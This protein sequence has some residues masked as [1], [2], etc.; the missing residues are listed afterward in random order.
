M[1]I[2]EALDS[3]RI[4]VPY[5]QH[6]W[7]PAGCPPKPCGRGWRGVAGLV[8]ALI[9]GG[10]LNFRA[11]ETEASRPTQV[12]VAYDSLSG[13]TEKAAAAVVEGARQLT[14]VQVT[15]KRVEAVVREDLEAADGLVLGC[16]TYYGTMPGRMKT[17]IDDWSWKMKVDLTDKVGGAFA[18]GGGQTGGKEFT[19][20]S[21]LMFMVNNRMVV[22]GPLYR[23]EKTGSVWAEAG[24]TAMTGPADPGVG[25]VELDSARR[26]GH[27]VAELA[28]KLRR[29]VS[30]ASRTNPPSA[31]APE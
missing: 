7:R 31:R 9:F 19:V 1:R 6:G 4:G 13:H 15:L 26:L 16:P 8:V 23:N 22:A 18:T 27:R 10:T 20:I 30:S 14:G 2:S 29:G 28:V 12:L 3:G 11:A 24:A 5:G 17:V 25:E 21:L